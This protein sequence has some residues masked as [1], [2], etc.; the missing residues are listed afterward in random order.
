MVPT[1]P[2]DDALWMIFYDGKRKRRVE[3]MNCSMNDAVIMYWF[4]NMHIIVIPQIK[5][6]SR[7]RNVVII[8]NTILRTMVRFL[9]NRCGKFEWVSVDHYLRFTRKK[10]P[11]WKMS[12]Y[13]PIELKAKVKYFCTLLMET[14]TRTIY[15]VFEN[16]A[17]TCKDAVALRINLV[18]G[19]QRKMRA[20]TC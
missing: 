1:K 4:V 20:G 7:R 14:K 10:N 5:M 9:F 13:Y 18:T 8:E 17:S 16:G 12:A 3:E 15:L 2:F 6:G 19:H 11:Y